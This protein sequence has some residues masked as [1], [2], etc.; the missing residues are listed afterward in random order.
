MSQQLQF[1]I[2]SALKDIIGKDLISD[3]Y[4]AIFELVS[5]P[6]EHLLSVPIV[7]FSR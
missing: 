1:K 7:L 3:D 5:F 4:I 2:S 6:E